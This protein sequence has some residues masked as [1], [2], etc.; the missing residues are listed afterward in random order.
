MTNYVF[1]YIVGSMGIVVAIVVAL[2]VG[3]MVIRCFKLSFRIKDHFGKRLLIAISTFFALQ[4][5][6]SIG[7][8]L[9]LLPIESVYMP[10]ISYS[11][12]GMTSAILLMAVFLGVYRR[13]DITSQEPV[14][15]SIYQWFK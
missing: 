2:L 9:G 1:N 6:L 4:Y 14:K 12:T 10:F 8:N 11:G 5:F 15:G 13:K 3:L 7:A